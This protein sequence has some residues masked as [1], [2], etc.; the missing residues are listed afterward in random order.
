MSKH[1]ELGV[2][3]IWLTFGY[4]AQIGLGFNINR[5]TL[6]IDLGPFYIGV[7]W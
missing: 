2:K 4:T 1:I 7:E 5:Y 6:S 3:K